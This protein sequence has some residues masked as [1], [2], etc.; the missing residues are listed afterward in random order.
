LKG[1]LILYDKF[2]QIIQKKGLTPYRVSKD[3][4]IPNSTLSDW[5]SGRS[6][7]K[8]DK[9]LKIANYLEVSVEEL[10]ETE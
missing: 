6:K 4:G 3:T 9:L 8:A 1:G 5:K 2:R 7:P 10:I